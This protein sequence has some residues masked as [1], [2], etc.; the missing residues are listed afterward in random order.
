MSQTIENTFAGCKVIRCQTQCRTRMVVLLYF[1]I[2][3][4]GHNSYVCVRSTCEIKAN[5]TSIATAEMFYEHI[6][7]PT[8]K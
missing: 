6:C 2:R 4:T 3:L 8:V 1:A 7:G 5:A